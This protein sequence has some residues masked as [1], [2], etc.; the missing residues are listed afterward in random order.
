MSQTAEE[1]AARLLGERMGFGRMMQL[2]QK[3]WRESLGDL[4]GGEFS[5]GPC[6]AVL[7]PCPHPGNIQAGDCDWCCGSG[8]VT[9]KV[10]AAMAAEV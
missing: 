8:R 4:A 2:G 5:I 10:L 6:V 1:K 9:K 7:V 3:L